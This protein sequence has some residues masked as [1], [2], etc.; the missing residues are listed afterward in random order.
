MVAPTDP[1]RVG[2]L[3]VIINGDVGALLVAVRQSPI[4]RRI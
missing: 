4:L 3:A 1:A 2:R